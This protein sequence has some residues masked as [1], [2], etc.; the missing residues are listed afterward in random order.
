LFAWKKEANSRDIKLYYNIEQ[1]ISDVY[2]IGLH[3]K[4]IYFS[5]SLACLTSWL[6]FPNII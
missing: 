3:K 2:T 1:N 5:Y 6:K 4:E